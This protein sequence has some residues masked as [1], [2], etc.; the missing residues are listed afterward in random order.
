[1][2]IIVLLG[3]LSSLLFSDSLDALLQEYKAT[4]DNSLQTVNEKIGH[5][6]IYSQ[7]EIRLMQYTKLNDILKELPLFNVNTNQLGLTNYSLTGSKT[8][9]SGFLLQGSN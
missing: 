3:L 5:V 8:T 6:V 7:K 9:T 4:S 2:K 1:M